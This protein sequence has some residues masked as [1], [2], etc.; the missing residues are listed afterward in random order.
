MKPLLLAGLSMATSLFLAYA[1]DTFAYT[2]SPW[3]M[4]RY[5]N[6]LII[7]FNIRV[8]GEMYTTTELRFP[9]NSKFRRY[10]DE[11]ITLDEL[12]Y[13]YFEIRA[14][15]KIQRACSLTLP[16]MD[17]ITKETMKDLL[18]YAESR[19]PVLFETSLSDEM[20]VS[21]LGITQNEFRQITPMIVPNLTK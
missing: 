4:A 8:E 10:F 17:I 20:I 2:A 6:D 1:E 21:V 11:R 5:N 19:K 16:R 3:Q 15:K 18:G 12:E 9:K 7:G 13:C 14:T